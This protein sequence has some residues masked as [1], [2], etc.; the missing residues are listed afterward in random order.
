MQV[1]IVEQT[2][3]RL[4]AMRYEGPV[5]NIGEVWGKLWAWT[6]ERGLTDKIEL[7]VG[8]CSKAP[9]GQGR[10]VY[11]AGLSL[12]GEPPASKDVEILNI[13]GGLYGSYRL[14]GSYSGIATAF[15]KLFSEWLPGSTYERDDRPALEIYR[16]NPYNTPEKDLITDLRVALKPR[17]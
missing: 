14:A 1:D 13:E 10:I 6:V 11:F 8:A 2:P 17:S 12:L 5:T 3:L 9:D 7:A 4:H 15:P 16:N